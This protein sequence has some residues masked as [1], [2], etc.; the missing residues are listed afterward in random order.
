MRYTNTNVNLILA[1]KP[2]SKNELKKLQNI[3][4]EYK[5]EDK[6]SILNEISEEKKINLYADCLATAFVPFEEDYGYITL[7]SFFSKKAVITT[8]DSGGPLEFVDDKKNGLIV[9]PDPKEI[10]SCMDTLYENKQN[11]QKMGENG[12]QKIKSMNLSWD[13]VVKSLTQ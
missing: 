5:L 8:N 11:S 7:E 4:N 12:F 6:V 9:N 13:N 10:A 2:E 1:G 3:I